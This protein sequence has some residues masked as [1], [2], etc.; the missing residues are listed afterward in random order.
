MSAIPAH[1]KLRTT[2][3]QRKA[4]SLVRCLV[5]WAY[6]RESVTAAVMVDCIV[7]GAGPNWRR[8]L[9]RILPSLR[10]QLIRCTTARN[11]N[12]NDAIRIHSGGNIYDG[13]L[14]GRS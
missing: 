14:G 4:A 3:S 13:L 12:A 1:L 8:R 2:A 9:L 7:N 10:W 11:E 5:L 6:S